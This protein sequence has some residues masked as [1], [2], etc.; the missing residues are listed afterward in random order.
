MIKN[1]KNIAFS[2]RIILNL[3]NIECMFDLR[4]NAKKTPT[5]LS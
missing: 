5:L 2:Y 1:G 4:K 3:P